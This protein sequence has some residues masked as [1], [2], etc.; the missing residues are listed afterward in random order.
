MSLDLDA[1]EARFSVATRAPWSVVGAELLRFAQA[2]VP[3]LTT[4]VRRLREEV[5]LQCC[6]AIPP[7][8]EGM[9][10][11]QLAHRLEMMRARVETLAVTFPGV[12]EMPRM[13]EHLAEPAFGIIDTAVRLEWAQEWLENARARGSA[14]RGARVDAEEARAEAEAAL[15]SPPTRRCLDTLTLTDRKGEGLAVMFQTCCNGE[16]GSTA[17]MQLEG[18]NL[19]D[20]FLFVA[21]M[22]LPWPSGFS[23]D[24]PRI[25][26]WVGRGEDCGHLVYTRFSKPRTIRWGPDFESHEM[27]VQEA[28]ELAGCLLAAIFEAERGTWP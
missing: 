12:E 11:E 1:I 22:V 7:H 18:R 20:L 15:V 10:A 25:R 4:E 19:E 26:G 2:D 21:P 8:L 24:R 27:S 13:L 5:S 16:M 23:N 17:E 3:L 9:T 14:E 6:Y 28:K